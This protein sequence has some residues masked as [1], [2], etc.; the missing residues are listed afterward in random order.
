MR[1]FTHACGRGLGHAR[2]V[3]TESAKQN[4]QGQSAGRYLGLYTYC[5][6]QYCMVYGM[7]YTREV[8]GGGRILPKSR[9]IVLQMQVGAGNEKARLRFVHKR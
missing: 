2:H 3:G 1:I 7:A 5:Y 8:G 4:V 9:A 6:Y